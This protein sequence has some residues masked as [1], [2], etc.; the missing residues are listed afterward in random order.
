MIGALNQ[1]GGYSKTDRKLE[2]KTSKNQRFS[3]KI[4]QK[5]NMFRVL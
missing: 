3:K 4:P 2:K 1:S 5:R